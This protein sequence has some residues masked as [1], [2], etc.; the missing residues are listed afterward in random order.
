MQM[1][2]GWPMQDYNTYLKY[3]I[4]NR[5]FYRRLKDNTDVPTN[6]ENRDYQ[7]LQKEI[8]EHGEENVIVRIENI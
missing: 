5:T 4:N 3:T 7:Q 6:I 1:D 2:I 8:T